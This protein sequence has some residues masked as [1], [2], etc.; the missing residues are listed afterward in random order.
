MNADNRHEHK[1]ASS[2]KASC[3]DELV[4]GGRYE[5]RIED[6]ADT[7]EARAKY[8]L[9]ESFSNAM[10]LGDALAYQMRYHEALIYYERSK[11]MRPNDYSAHRKCAGRYFSTFQ[12]DKAAYEFLW[13]VERARDKLDPL[14]MLG[15]VYYCRKEFAKGKEI[16]AQ[17]LALA[18]NDGDMYVGSLYWLIACEIRMGNDYSSFL[19]LFDE[20]IE[21]GHHTGYLF[22]L[23]TFKEKAIDESRMNGEDEIQRCIFAYGAHLYCLAEKDEK[24]SKLYLDKALALD[25]YFASFAYLAAYSESIHR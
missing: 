11:M 8:A 24:T 15:C 20:D 7:K 12:L 2:I 22:S 14:Y 16:F 5:K 9:E 19:A 3:V 6:D 1:L 13:C 17:C 4:N 18:K 21:I 23:K 10:A 25:T